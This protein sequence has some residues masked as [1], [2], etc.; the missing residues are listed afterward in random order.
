[1]IYMTE[2]VPVR[3]LKAS[4]AVPSTINPSFLIFKGKK[5]EEERASTTAR[6]IISLLRI[7]LGWLFTTMP[8]ALHWTVPDPPLLLC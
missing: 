6:L 3:L 7:L 8:Y 2:L 4:H 5:E 1:M